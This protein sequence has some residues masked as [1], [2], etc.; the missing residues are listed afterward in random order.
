MQTNLTRLTLVIVLACTGLQA[1]A[2][3]RL[4]D[5]TVIDRTTGATLPLHYSKG[6]YW[7]AG[8]PGARYAIAIRNKMGERVMAVTSVDGVNVLNG[9]TASWDQ[10]GYVFGGYHNYQITGW[11][12]SNS[13]VAAFEFS[14]SNDSYAERTGRPNQVGVIGVA[15]FRERIHQPIAV[16]TPPPSPLSYREGRA[17]EASHQSKAAPLAPSATAA[18]AEALASRNQAADAAATQRGDSWTPP[19]PKLGTG[20]GQREDSYVSQTSFERLRSQPNEIITIR[21]DSRENLIAAGVISERPAH[22]PNPFPNSDSFSYVPGP[23][24][25]RY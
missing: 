23:P 3:G 7:V 11:R 10:T 20:H 25:R 4:A 22:T 21:Y 13:E 12:K 6:Q 15:L 19:S 16:P 1:Q 18:P 24:A 5:V 14:A 8:A 17:A 9:A 2:V